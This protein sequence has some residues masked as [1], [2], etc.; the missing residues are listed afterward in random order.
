MQNLMFS[1]TDQLDELRII[2]NSTESIL[3]DE[4]TERN[5]EITSLR[6]EI[7]TQNV[8][9]FEFKTFSN[10]FDN[11]LKSQIEENKKLRAEIT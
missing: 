4:I 9:N 10:S 2:K 8:K 1:H 7:A 6:M 11:I 5:E 3:K